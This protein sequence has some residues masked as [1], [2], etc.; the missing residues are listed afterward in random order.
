MKREE[1]AENTD[2]NCITP[3]AWEV[4]KLAKTEVASLKCAELRIKN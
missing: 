1:D 2:E 3:N 4:L